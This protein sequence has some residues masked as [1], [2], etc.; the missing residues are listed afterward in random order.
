[1]PAAAPTPAAVPGY[2]S[3][4]PYGSPMPE[5]GQLLVRYPEEMR[6]GAR[7]GAPAWW[8]VVVL[9][10]ISGLLGLISASRRAARARRGR[11]SVAPYW[12][13]FA[14]SFVASLSLGVVL[15]PAVTAAWQDFREAAHTKAVERNLVF[16][17]RLKQT[18]R[19]TVTSAR[20]EPVGERGADDLRR[21]TCL[22]RLD[23]GGTGTVD[24]TAD[25][26]GVWTAVPLKK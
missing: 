12:I 13:A 2:G 3:V 26:A 19:V 4:A 7:T 22:L 5:Y 18:N 1:V 8:P 11:N 23:G 24:L 21:Y 10:M 6:S 17:G 14:T 16:D 9:T 25:S 20:C 15:Q